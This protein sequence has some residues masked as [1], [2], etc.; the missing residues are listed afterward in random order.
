MNFLRKKK[1]I[2]LLKN[3][4][5]DNILCFFAALRL[6]LIYFLARHNTSRHAIVQNVAGSAPGIPT[7]SAPR[8]SALARLRAGAG[9]GQARLSLYMLEYCQRVRGMVDLMGA[10]CHNFIT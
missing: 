8:V 9:V 5:L 7:T 3:F 4:F 2:I 6:I 1:S 10:W